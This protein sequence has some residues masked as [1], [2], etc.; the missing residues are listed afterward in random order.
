MII[1]YVES[2]DNHSP[3][4][5]KYKYI[6]TWTPDSGNVKLKG[7]SYPDLDGF[8][9]AG[10]PEYRC[11]LT[12][13]RSYLGR[14]QQI[15]E[16]LLPLSNIQKNVPR[17]FDIFPNINIVV[18]CPGSGSDDV[19]KFDAIIFDPRDISLTDVP[20]SRLAR[21]YY[22]YWNVEAPL[23]IWLDKTD[24]ADLQSFFN[25]SMGYRRDADFP[26]P[27][28]SLQQVNSSSKY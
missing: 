28:G 7:W 1:Q 15:R 8:K 9:K 18:H 3:D 21:Q 20:V 16:G 22:I 12:N 23:W 6:L 5:N 10:C 19:E 11:Y 2:D 13:N 26:V 4:F 25:W 14:L 17:P 27:Y 24:L